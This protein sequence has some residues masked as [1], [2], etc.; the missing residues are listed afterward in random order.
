MNSVFTIAQ[1]STPKKIQNPGGLERYVASINNA[2]SEANGVRILSTGDVAISL[3]WLLQS[4]RIALHLF[5]NI[6]KFDVIESHFILTGLFSLILIR[7]PIV[8]FFH[9][10]W[11]EERS[12]S[13]SQGKLL[14]RIRKII[15]RMYLKRANSIITVGKSM[16]EYLIVEH[17]I[18]VSKISVV[19]AGV[20]TSIFRFNPS[21]NQE[22]I[23]FAARRIEARMGILELITAWD[24]TTLKNNAQLRI[25]GTGSQL[26]EANHLI[27]KLELSN[28]VSMLGRVSE[29]V[30]VAEYQNAAIS[31]IPTSSLEG[32]GLVCL[33]SFSCGTPVISTRVGE[34]EFLV[35][36]KWPQFTYESGKPQ[37]LAKILDF[38]AANRH[39]LPTR[40]QVKEYSTQFT[41]EKT[42]SNISDVYKKIQL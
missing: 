6:K 14:Y 27:E 2:R 12:V 10:P 9:S 3:H 20:D 40:N 5:R 30:L 37:E 17:G 7:K 8:I 36:E 33:E 4:F 29:E 1:I 18:P 22:L 38:V 26:T 15:E 25:A 23:V 31:I 16:R 39:A 24:M 34:L 21:T 32:F 42:I 41:W 11:A 28:S 19:G 35:A 13:G